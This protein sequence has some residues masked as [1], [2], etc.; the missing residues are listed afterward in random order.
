MKYGNQIEHL[1]K[2][3][4]LLARIYWAND[5]ADL[6][7]QATTTSRSNRIAVRR[8]ASQMYGNAVSQDVAELV[9]SR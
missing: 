8:R 4:E 5:A 9:L 3:A 2:Q 6:D 7:S 1:R